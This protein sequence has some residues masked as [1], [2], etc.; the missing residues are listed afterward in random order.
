MDNTWK[1][2]C[3]L[4]WRAQKRFTH[5]DHSRAA[6]EST[7]GLAKAGVAPLMLTATP[8]VHSLPHVLSF[9]QPTSSSRWKTFFLCRLALMA[10]FTVWSFHCTVGPPKAHLNEYQCRFA[11]NLFFQAKTDSLFFCSSKQV[12]DP[13]LSTDYCWLNKSY[14]H[15]HTP[16]IFSYPLA[17]HISIFSYLLS[18]ELFGGEHG[19]RLINDIWSS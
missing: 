2:E 5:C 1:D 3:S 4:R 17:T 6:A 16:T 10:W 18:Q 7:F 15:T 8:F 9:L 12:P 11:F 19:A 13:R 14:T